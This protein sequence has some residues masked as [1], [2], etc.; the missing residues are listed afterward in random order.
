M[1]EAISALVVLGYTQTEAAGVIAAQPADAPVDEL[2]K[3]GLRALAGS[4]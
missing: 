2:I 4:R 1:A 3:A